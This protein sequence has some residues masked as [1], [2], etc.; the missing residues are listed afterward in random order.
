MRILVSGASGFVGSAI[1]RDLT[2][3][4]HTVLPLLRISSGH[5]LAWDP[6]R[7]EIADAQ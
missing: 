5:L 7:G 6:A 2:G 3:E 4:G 1:T